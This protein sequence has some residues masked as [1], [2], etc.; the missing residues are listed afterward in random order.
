MSVALRELD[1]EMLWA[2]GPSDV[3]KCTQVYL[4]TLCFTVYIPGLTES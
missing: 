4:L 3:Y 2:A 1:V